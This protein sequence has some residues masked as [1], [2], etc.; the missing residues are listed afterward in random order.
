MAVVGAGP[1]G[2]AA[3]YHL[4]RSGRTVALL[5]R[6]AFPRDKSCGDA[7]TRAGV[8]LLEEM[9]VTEDLSAARE[10]GALRVS[11]GPAGSRRTREFRYGTGARDGRFGL[12]VTRAV[13]DAAIVRRAVRAGA[14]LYER[15]DVRRL[16]KTEGV[17]TGI[18]FTGPRGPGTMRARVVVAADGALSRI[19][20]QAGLAGT[21]RTSLGR[22][23]RAY[24]TGVDDLDDSL[25]LFM[26]LVGSPNGGV[27]PAYGWMF[28]VGGRV[29]NV[30][31]GLLER[32]SDVRLD[33]LF[34]RFVGELR[35]SFPGF[36]DARRTNPPRA[37][38]LRVDF[39]PRRCW[40]PG[41][42]LVGEAAGLVNPGTGEGISFALESG[43]IAAGVI[44]DRLRA[45]RVE[46]LSG[47]AGLLSR[48]FSG[49]AETGRFAASRHRLAWNVLQDTFDSEKPIFALVRHAALAP[50]HMMGFGT[51]SLFEDVGACLDDRLR[52]AP[53]LFE[54]D[55]ILAD[56][57]RREWPF[58]VRLQSLD[59]AGRTFALR[60]ALLAL[61]AAQFGNA[62]RRRLAPLAA[63]TDLANIAA[64]AQAGVGT[65]SRR[66]APNWGTKFAIL[67]GDLL[68]T[69]AL[70][71]CVGESPDLTF[72]LAEILEEAC[73]HRMRALQVGRS[74]A[75]GPAE[76]APLT[77]GA[78]EL[79][80]MA[81]GSTVQTVDAL[82][83]YGRNLGSLLQLRED[84]RPHL[85]GA[86]DR[87]G[88]GESDELRQTYAHIEEFG[89]A[90]LAALGPL[91]PG[92]AR[93]S[94]HEIV[95][96]LLTT[97]RPPAF[98]SPPPP[99]E[100]R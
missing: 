18:E 77:A 92:P 50:D 81:T 67:A 73:R 8:G 61:L 19:A 79:G 3:A 88:L 86:R 36:T 34:R 33:D 89:R 72:R 11:M 23:L 37:A 26:P 25:R 70:E 93:H 84:V 21:S 66:N 47:Y 9:G 53:Q 83:A 75:A 60:P 16:V 95:R 10:I 29:A 55:E 100:E 62:G 22:A 2:A 35:T 5:E 1:A 44:D 54:V 27:L 69:R 65:E 80:A 42:V 90:A 96:H 28:P 14:R 32:R 31:V 6:A 57:V 76:A 38:P 97:A 59:P 85:S 56:T 98:T 15:A 24:F 94:L 13:L 48:R 78:C 63:A 58:L 52:L 12:V 20:R 82:R 43:K 45:G 91:S 39:D 7:V 68:L 46:D 49:Y 99:K 41:I 17:V 74:T 87:R 71:L 40:A 64:L 30:G 4:A 51:A